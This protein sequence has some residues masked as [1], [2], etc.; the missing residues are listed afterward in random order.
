MSD[1]R[2]T[3][4][5]VLAGT[6]PPAEFLKAVDEYLAL[7]NPRLDALRSLIDAAEH[8]GLPA[9]IA[10]AARKR[11]PA[12]GTPSDQPPDGNDGNT[13]V[14]SADD[15]RTQLTT[16]AAPTVLRASPADIDGDRTEITGSGAGDGDRTEVSGGDDRTVEVSGGD[17]RTVEVAGGADPFAMAGGAPSEGPGPGSVLKG[18]FRLEEVIG[19]GGMGAVYKAVDLLKVEARDRNPY[20]AVKLLIGDFKEHPEAFIA[21]QRESAKAQRLAHPNIATVYDFDRD[22]ETVY[23]T[24]EL[25]VG[26]ELAKYIKKLPAGGLPVAEAN[27]II[28]QL[29]SGLQYAHARGLVHSDFKPGN[30]F[31]LDDGTV[32]LLDFGIARASKTKGD[33]EGESTVFDPGQLGA[34]TPAYATIEMFEG[35]D[36]DPRDD[37]YA[38][39]CVAYELYTGKHP[40]NKMSAVKAKE[41]G[42]KPAPVAKLNKRQNKT[43]LKALALHRDDRLATVELFWEGLKP[44]KDYTLQIAAGATA[45]IVLIGLLA[46]GPIVNVIHEREHAA[47]IAEVDSGDEARFVAGL[48]QIEALPDARRRTVAERAQPRIVQYFTD[49]AD[50]VAN[51]AEGRYDYP[52]A[53][54]EVDALAR[55]FPNSGDVVNLRNQIEGER[56]RL[57]NTL[58]TQFEERLEDGRIL[59]VENED[60]ITDVL[61]ILKV[62]Q[63]DSDLLIDPRLVSKYVALADAQTRQQR[64]QEADRIIGIGLEFASRNPELLDRRDRVAAE[65]RREQEAAMVA[66]LRDQLRSAQPRVLADFRSILEPLQQ[67]GEL[68]PADPA[69]RTLDTALRRAVDGGI[70][71][72]AAANDWAGADALLAEFA[73]T[74]SIAALIELRTSLTERQR[75]AG[76]DTRGDAEH[77]ADLA[78]RTAAIRTLLAQPAFDDAFERALTAQFKELTAR[79]DLEIGEWTTLREEIAGAYVARARALAVDNRYAVAVAALDA[80]QQFHAD[81]PAFAAERQTLAAAEREYLAEV[82]RSEALAALNSRKEQLRGYIQ[83]GDMQRAVAEFNRLRRD[84][85]ADDPFVATEAPQALAARYATLATELGPSNPAQAA[86]MAEAGLQVLPGHPELT[87][88]QNRYRS[89]AAQAGARA[90]AAEVTAQ[91]FA[92]FQRQYADARQGLTGAEATQFET[93]VVTALATRLTELDRAGNFSAANELRR[94]ALQ[95]FPNNQRL[96]QLQLRQPSQFAVRVRESITGTRLTE[97]DARLAEGRRAEG[98]DHPDL[99]SAGEL[100]EERKAAAMVHYRNALTEQQRGNR[101]GQ[102]QALQQAVAIWSDNVQFQEMQRLFT[103]TTGAQRADDGSRACTA[104]LAGL[105]ARGARAAC[106]DMVA[107]ARGPQLVVVA[108]ISG[109]APFA[110][111]KYEVTIGEYNHFCRNGGGCQPVAG[112]DAH[113]VT[114][115]T[116][117]NADAYIAWLSQTTGNAYRLPSDAE[118][119]YAAGGGGDPGRSADFNC[120]VVQGGSVIKGL[121]VLPATTGPANGWGITN[122]VGNAQEWTRNGTALQARGGSFED[123]FSSCEV[124][125]VKPHGGGADAATGFRVMRGIN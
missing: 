99:R 91:N 62:A 97:A 115:I 8:L 87:A 68:R 60:D 107:G 37:I 45:G 57:V 96:T 103:G 66:S 106:Y 125:L 4:N 108:G 104:N 29:C 40:F 116:I 111:G 109:G 110:V 95:V 26:A 77:N 71:E 47:I 93:A 72:L 32:K 67:L 19:Q 43:L 59:P 23:M 35:Q 30:A 74:L 98:A 49:R 15:E 17:D 52:A 65:L 78:R 18:R 25:M 7:P 69:V 80:G 94:L 1:I 82:A 114:G 90:R 21:L 100:L 64:W 123:A 120:R 22:G 85:P 2:Q 44:R 117:Q 73:R 34:L 48:A 86:Q 89:A 46:Y 13:E 84:L 119:V 6:L 105:G 121:S 42:L 5:Q 16:G 54:A 31:L 14:L 11:I 53:L 112:D 41:K 83:A 33:T 50:A 36:P 12:G 79:A 76:Y 81:L 92:A 20:M 55:F 70:A 38:L 118:W 3:L 75:A 27:K 102:Q 56:T 63:P 122:A 124:G 51:E 61:R 58:R 10:A 113:P 39:A 101:P 28:E 9:N 24:M 88:L